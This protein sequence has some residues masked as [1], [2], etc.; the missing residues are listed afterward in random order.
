[1][2]YINIS[3]LDDRE[4][5]YIVLK[6]RLS[7]L[8]ITDKECSY[9]AASLSVNVGSY[10]DPV[11][12]QGLA[13]FLEHML[14][15]GTEKYPD[16]NKFME[17]IS[18]NG[19]VN[20]AYTS[21]D[22]TNYFYSILNHK[23]KESLD[24]FS[25]FF[26][27]P[28]FNKNSVLKEVQAVHSEHSKNINNDGRR[29]FALLSHLSNKGSYYNKFSTGNLETLLKHN[30]ISNINNKNLTKLRDELINFYNKYYSANIMKLVLL[31]NMSLQEQ[32]KIV[33]KYFIDIPDKN[34]NPELVPMLRF[35]L[36]NNGE[37]VLLKYIKLVPIKLDHIIEMLWELPTK[38][39]YYK[40][41]IFS[42][43]S[44]IIGHENEGSLY[45]ILKNKHLILS[46]STGIADEDKNIT[47]FN[48]TVS[49]T[50]KG[51][52][53]K[54]YIIASIFKYIN[55]LLSSEINSYIY[56]DVKILNKQSFIYE[57][58]RDEMDTVS[59]YS[60][61]MLSY[62]IKKVISEK[63]LMA[64]YDINVSK[65]LQKYIKLLK[66]ESCIII[67][68]SPNYANLIRI[69]N[70]NKEKWYNIKYEE[71]T[72]KIQKVDDK[73]DFKI[74][75]KNIYISDNFELKPLIK[76]VKYPYKVY[77]NYWFKQEHKF[78]TPLSI[79]TLYF[80]CED[81]FDVYKYIALKLYI[82][83][84]LETYNEHLYDAVVSSLNYNITVSRKNNAI[85]INLSG[86]SQK[87]IR[88]LEFILNKLS[89]G[90]EDEQTFD[91]CKRKFIKVY[92]NYIYMTSIKLAFENWSS[93]V[94][95]TYIK[96]ETKLDVIN[97]I[98]FNN[99]NNIKSVFNRKNITC[100]VHGNFIHE[101]VDKIKN[102]INSSEIVINN[103]NFINDIEK[104]T[105]INKSVL[106]SKEL[107]SCALRVYD[108]EYN[109]SIDD[110]EW[111]NFNIS[112]NIFNLSIGDSFFDILR[113]KEQLGYVVKNS[114]KTFGSYNKHK[115]CYY[116][117]VQSN[118][119]DPIYIQDRI[120]KYI[121]NFKKSIDKIKIKELLDTF[122]KTL[123]QKKINIYEVNSDYINE[124]L[125]Q[126][127]IFN[128]KDILVNA[129]NKYTLNNLKDFIE[130]YIGNV[131][132][133][134]NVFGNIH[135][136]KMKN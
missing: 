92:E 72:K 45:Y 65:L 46:L 115:Y 85:L 109:K 118:T 17:F 25:Q 119:K 18:D 3:R 69:D 126:E 114:I 108:L 8:L 68:S 53:K 67:S 11:K 32:E 24:I 101:D 82:K 57:S 89:L 19:G 128:R 127:Y 117:F 73:I 1:M 14:F 116:F 113:T 15:M 64:E 22:H 106:N 123:Q 23:F 61:N 93:I 9:S 135:L 96:N 21:S 38:E 129:C 5:K 51:F 50:K 107:N 34:V 124:I 30:D 133:E 102:I 29:V 56:N 83:V 86:F 121:D 2:T 77:D 81:T 111:I 54:D 31:S 40:Y 132:I 48:I 95:K 66:P 79:I 120:T 28:L 62:D 39:K 49:L 80:K 78:K 10:H 94:D 84:I 105:I 104:H 52:N 76:D 110:P 71:L 33:N 99:I 88:L 60:S 6:N 91:H 136:D 27:S 131:Y 87:L 16:E 70:K 37:N 74:P 103:D 130:K 98:K 47:I 90:I 44:H 35:P 20:N 59:E 100:F 112:M 58:K 134:S 13:H 97:S 4:Y 7:V 55:M 26:I 75:G 12:Y 122:I 42:V 43:L 41:N 125:T 63:R 36:K